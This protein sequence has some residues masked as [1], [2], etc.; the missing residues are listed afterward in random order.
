LAKVGKERGKEIVEANVEKMRE[1]PA[2][3]YI[4]LG[5]G[6]LKQHSKAGALDDLER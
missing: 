4:N 2:V 6:N 1:P 5:S 3:W